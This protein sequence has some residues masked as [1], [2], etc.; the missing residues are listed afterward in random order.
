MDDKNKFKHVMPIAVNVQKGKTYEWCS[1]GQSTTPPLCDKQ[2]ADCNY[3]LY[4]AHCNETVYFCGCKKTKHPPLC[5]GSHAKI[6]IEMMK[7]TKSGDN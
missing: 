6:L 7:K 2:T 1:C 5:D 4:Q 3:H